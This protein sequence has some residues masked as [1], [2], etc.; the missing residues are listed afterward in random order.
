[1]TCQVGPDL[2]KGQQYG[3]DISDSC[4]NKM[5]SNDYTTLILFIQ[6]AIN[7]GVCQNAVKDEGSFRSSFPTS[8]FALDALPMYSPAI[9]TR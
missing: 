8:D 9:F 1:M 6:S 5:K 3:A 2:S 7:D 4:R